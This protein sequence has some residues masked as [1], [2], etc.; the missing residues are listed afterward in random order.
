MVDDAFLDALFVSALILTHEFPDLLVLVVIDLVLQELRPKEVLLV[1]LEQVELC[2][3]LVLVL[4][5]EPLLLL[6][7]LLL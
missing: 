4:R 2:L 7:E 5:P 1:L 3:G 6:P